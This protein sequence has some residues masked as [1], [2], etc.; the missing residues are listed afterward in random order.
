MVLGKGTE[1]SFTLRD[2]AGFAIIESAQNSKGNIPKFNRYLKGEFSD[3]YNINDDIINRLDTLLTKL[4]DLPISYFE[5]KPRRAVLLNEF[6]AAV[7]PDNATQDTRDILN[8]N[9]ISVY[10]YKADDDADRLAKVN[11]AAN[12]NDILFSAADTESK[13]QAKKLKQNNEKWKRKVARTKAKY[14]EKTDRIKQRYD[15][16]LEAEKAR[17]ADRLETQKSKASDRL[18]QEK[19][20]VKTV[21]AQDAQKLRDTKKDI[22]SKMRDTRDRKA[23]VESI[24]SNVTFLTQ[25]LLKPTDT[26]HIPMGIEDGVARVL[27]GVDFGTHRMDSYAEKHGISKTAATYRMLANQYKLLARENENEKEGPATDIIYD[28]GLAEIIQALADK[29]DT[30][31]GQTMGRVRLENMSTTDLMQVRQLMSALSHAVS[32]VNTTYTGNQKQTISELSDSVIRELTPLKDFTKGRVGTGFDQYFNVANAKP[33]DFFDRLGSKTLI[34]SF[35]QLR[36]AHDKF[37]LN[38]KASQD[39]IRE[40]KKKHGLTTKDMKTWHGNDLS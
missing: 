13:L 11:K 1:N 21:R 4:K 16:R 35:S 17:A 34:D 40:A 12:D 30:L 27:Y 20:K 33:V 37:I 29:F 36:D 14:I 32:K 10:E 39:F 26:V 38:M 23:M 15:A 6:K 24:R 25:A 9:G 7:I 8:S 19:D 5:A 18:Q 28:L 22:R 31:D 3:Y 2:G